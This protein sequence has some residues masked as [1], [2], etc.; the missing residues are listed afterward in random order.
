MKTMSDR[1][2]PM[3][4]MVIASCPAPALAETAGQPSQMTDLL[5]ASAARLK[6][7]APRPERSATFAAPF[8]GVVTP[9]D[10]F[11]L[12]QT[13]SRTMALAIGPVDLRFSASRAYHGG[14]D[15]IG[16]D[17]WSMKGVGAAALIPL[18]GS[19]G[20]IIGGDFARMSRRLQIV[21]VNPHRLST[22]MARVG[23]ALAFGDDSR[24]SLDY[25]SI[26]RSAWQDDLTRL[27]ET[28]GGAPLTGHGPELAF[29]CSNQTGRRSID[30]RFSLDA[31]Q[32]P[33]IDLGLAG[34]MGPRTDARALASLRF[35]L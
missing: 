28:I 30:W 12:A 34:Q 25:L 24:I 3:A 29:A 2:W 5:M 22:R 23:M 11:N 26:A 13:R 1:W 7:T 4:I 8:A 6:R 31:M 16:T 35:H 15:A 18:I 17:R 21:D 9:M 14:D 33:A 19:L 20:L 10:Q 32:R 27:A